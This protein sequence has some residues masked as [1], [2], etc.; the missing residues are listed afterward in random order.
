MTISRLML[1]AALG[2]LVLGIM[3]LV[4]ARAEAATLFDKHILL[5]ADDAPPADADTDASGQSSAKMG[6]EPGT[7]TG[8]DQGTTPEKRHAEDRSAATPQRN[9]DRSFWRPGRRRQI[10]RSSSSSRTNGLDRRG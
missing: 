1:A 7:H 4:P 2:A 3:G 8:D 6:E 5:A 9:H 10:G